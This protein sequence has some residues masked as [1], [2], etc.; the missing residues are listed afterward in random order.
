MKAQK[1]D[2]STTQ[3]EGSARAS[4]EPR[5]NRLIPVILAGGSGTR[6]WPM[7]R[8]YLPKQF[9]P[10]TSEKTMLQETLLRLEGLD[11]AK[12]IVVV[13]EEH[14][15]LAAEQLRE[16]GIEA[17]IL[18][19][20]EG[21]NTA[22]AIALAANYA[23]KRDSQK[24][25][26]KGDQNLLVLAAD[27]AIQDIPSFHRAIAHAMQ[28]ADS[29]KLVTFGIVPA[30]ANTGYGYIKKGANG[31]LP[32]QYAV[33]AFVEKPDQGKADQY[34][35][36]GDYLWN[37]GMFMF[38]ADT[39]LGELQIYAEDIAKPC[40]RSIENIRMD[41]DFFRIEAAEFSKSSA[42]SVDYA[43]MEKTDKAAV[44]PL[45]AGWSDVGSWSALADILQKDEQGNVVK[46]CQTIVEDTK[47][48]MVMGDDRLISV[49]GVEDLVVVDT[50]DALLVA[51]KSAIQ[52]GG[53][54]I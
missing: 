44:V 10:L 11:C 9:L 16:I 34:L 35:A 53:F 43:V 22:P 7:S 25:E 21:K 49:L 41:L 39:F 52:D 18:L 19:E 23:L 28:I 17:D 37:S 26:S 14:R 4:D 3:Y 46:N 12:P 50:K 2:T 8:K 5:S 24:Q 40:A 29:G 20:P 31:S 38:R 47:N 42:E 51:H 13:G 27:H 48:C 30:E 33:D 45:D 15:F 36:S 1:L 54:L 6:L 32:E